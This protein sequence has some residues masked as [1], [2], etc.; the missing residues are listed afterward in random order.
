MRL[1]SFLPLAAVA[2]L[3]HGAALGQNPAPGAPP[4]AAEANASPA[5]DA[6][7]NYDANLLGGMFGLRPALAAN[8]LTLN[9]TDTSEG[10]GNPTGG[11]RQEGVF[12]GFGFASLA[13]DGSKAGLWDGFSALVSAWDIYGRGLTANALGNLHTISNAEA[14]RAL[15]LFELWAEQATPD[16]RLSLRVGQ[17][18]A[19]QEFMVDQYATLFVNADYG[20]PD[21]A[22][23]DLPSGGPAYPLGTP[24][25]RLKLMP[26]DSV[27]VLLALFN[28]DPVPRGFGDDPQAREGGGTSFRTDGGALWF[29]EAQ[30]ARNQGKDATGL[31]STFKIGA[32]Y[33]SGYFADQR[34]GADGL[35][36]ADPASDG[37][38][39]LRHGDFSIYALADQVL[40][41]PA[42]APDGG[43]AAFL[44]VM[45]APADRNLVEFSLDS[46]VTW[47]GILP[48]RGDD[49]AGLGLEWAR[50]GDAASKLD[51]DIARFSG[52]PYPVRR[53]EAVLELTYQAQIKPWWQVQPD[54]QYVVRPGGGIPELT[55]P[56]Q[57]AGDALVLGARSIVTF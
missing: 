23:N 48:D 55:D 52:E 38:E 3:A 47:K 49:T 19:D 53:W 34:F 42:G 7:T 26:S 33:H 46:G 36:L 54:I 13:L 22:S 50:V 44:R 15:L 35:S 10:L 27:T 41:R 51:G 30:W 25:V 45:G 39:L 29:A 24:A 57:R 1:P 20:F 37:Q 17:Q 2:I 43:I 56:T 31:P 8:G 5:T 6:G 28:G 11:L 14:D 4:G 16:G 18:A 32:W 21:L 12:E 9:L 40:W